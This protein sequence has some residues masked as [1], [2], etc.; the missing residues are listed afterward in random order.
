MAGRTRIQDILRRVTRLPSDPRK[1]YRQDAGRPEEC[2]V[3]GLHM[4]RN[5]AQAE[6]VRRACERGML[7]CTDCRE[8]LIRAWSAV[9]D[10]PTRD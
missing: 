4:R 10:E 6:S 5:A 3:F 2:E 1:V 9:G 8:R 7:G